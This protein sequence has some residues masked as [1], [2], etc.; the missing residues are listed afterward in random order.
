MPTLEVSTTLETMTCPHCAGVFA[1]SASFLSEARVKGNFAQTWA[2]PYCKEARG[3][4]KGSHQIEKEKLEAKLAQLERMKAMEEER[5]AYY[6]KEAEHFRKSRDG[7]KGALTRERNRVGNGV[8][9]CCDRTF[10]N[11]QRHM[12]SKHP[13]HTTKQIEL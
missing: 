12:A 10:V 2:C 1:I 11:L 4:G 9:P 7:M 5:K 8:C 6:K 3:Y 13:D